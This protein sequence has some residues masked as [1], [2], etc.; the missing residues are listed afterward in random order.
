MTLTTQA[1]LH[2]LDNGTDYAVI[3]EGRI[4]LF[5]S[6]DPETDTA[7]ALAAMNR[8]GVVTMIDSK[9]RQPRTI[10]NIARAAK[11]TVSDAP[12]GRPRFVKWKPAPE[13]ARQTRGGSPSSPEGPSA[14]TEHPAGPQQAVG[15]QEAPNI[16]EDDLTPSFPDEAT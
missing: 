13:I 5:R 1:R 16:P 6:R 12:S 3:C 2:L 14:S 15:S 7:R 10:V 8:R 4:L 9:T 11:L